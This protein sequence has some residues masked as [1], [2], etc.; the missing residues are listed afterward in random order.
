MKAIRNIN[1]LSALLERENATWQRL[2]YE[3]TN[4]IPIFSDKYTLLVS[5]CGYIDLDSDAEYTYGK[6]NDLTEYCDIESISDLSAYI[7]EME[8]YRKY[9]IDRSFGQFSK[10]DLFWAVFCRILHYSENL[11]SNSGSTYQ[12]WH[13]SSIHE[14]EGKIV[15]D[16]ALVD[17]DSIEISLN[18][19]ADTTLDDALEVLVT[20]INQINATVDELSKYSIDHIAAQVPH[21]Y[22]ELQKSIGKGMIL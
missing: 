4:T 10:S 14:D 8:S 21:T 11:K 6:G 2:I 7:K 5:N 16:M 19:E 12:A 1:H 3:N 18:I 20:E 13:L 9:L 17:Y 22:D 15:L